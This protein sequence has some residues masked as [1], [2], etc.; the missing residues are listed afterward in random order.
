VIPGPPLLLPVCAGGGPA[1]SSQLGP[2]QAAARSFV[3]AA[4]APP[5]PDPGSPARTGGVQA[6]PTPGGPAMRSHVQGTVYLLHFTEPY[7]HARHYTGPRTCQPGW[8]CTP[9]GVARGWS[10]SSSP[11]A[12]ASSWRAPGRAIGSW[13][14]RSSAAAWRRATAPSAARLAAVA[15]AEPVGPGEGLPVCP[16]L[17]PWPAAPFP[18]GGAKQ[19]KRRGQLTPA[20][21][22]PTP[23]PA[24]G[25]GDR[26]SPGR[27]GRMPPAG[28]Q[29][30]DRRP[31]CARARGAP[32]PRDL[33]ADPC[34]AGGCHPGPSGVKGAARP[35][36]SACGAP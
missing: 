10:R 5:C 26:T 36:G 3:L 33:P 7:K 22:R 21:R 25:P 23:H 13:S 30:E 6:D 18:V 16:L 19:G 24:A 28:T 2:P 1:W 4:G 34:W 9:K 27:L 17:P 35:C 32:A 20:A 15:V 14:G 29:G 12:S 31:R 8:R 11:R